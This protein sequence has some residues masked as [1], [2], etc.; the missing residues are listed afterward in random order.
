MNKYPDFPI[1]AADFN[2][3]IDDGRRNSK[4]IDSMPRVQILTDEASHEF[5]V[6]HPALL[7]DEVEQLLKFYRENLMLEFEF[8]NPSDGKTYICIFY[9]APEFGNF[10]ALRKDVTFVLAGREK[11]G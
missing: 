7:P 3:T 1:L 9:S 2:H 11:V 6:T 10:I 8:Y 5:S 4:T